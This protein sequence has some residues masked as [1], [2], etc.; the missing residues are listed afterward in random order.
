MSIAA[1]GGAYCVC[2]LTALEPEQPEDS[3]F[4]HTF[5]ENIQQIE[6]AFCELAAIQS[7]RPHQ[8]TAVLILSEL[9]SGA[10]GDYAC[11]AVNGKKPP[12][13]YSFPEPA[14][15]SESAG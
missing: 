1:A 15:P 4:R 3:D 6:H 9:Y 10:F 12:L 14:A 13:S 8:G 7:F 5:E 11:T 2:V